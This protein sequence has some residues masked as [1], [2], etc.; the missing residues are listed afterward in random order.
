MKFT[1]IENNNIS[2]KP[3]PGPIIII[4]GIIDVSMKLC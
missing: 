2:H 1:K 3:Q 4:I